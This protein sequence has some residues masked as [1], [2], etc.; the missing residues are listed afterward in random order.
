VTA[1]GVRL[2]M[3]CE[4]R[5][6][7]Q[8]LRRLFRTYRVGR[9]HITPAPSGEGAASHWVAQQ[10]EKVLKLARLKKH[11]ANLG[12]MVVVDGDNQG[13]R[14]R[15]RE[16]F[17]GLTDNRSPDMKLAIWVPTWSIE[18]WVMLLSGG[19]AASPADVEKEVKFEVKKQ[20]EHLLPIA[21]SSWGDPRFSSGSLD[22]AR[23]ELQRLP[24][25]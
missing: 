11:Q 19:F 3:W 4:D 8:F 20:W 24:I 1:S 12:F 25:K 10:Y 23:I 21:V 15:K 7:E 22:D 9:L 5:G 18:T 14:A 16:L 13:L 17:K 2:E 6:Q